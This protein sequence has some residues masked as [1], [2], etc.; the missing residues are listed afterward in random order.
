[1]QRLANQLLSLSSVE[2]INGLAR[3]RAPVDLAV[4][5][6]DVAAD[7][8]LLAIERQIDLGFESNL[9]GSQALPVWGHD[10]LLRDMVLNLVDNALRYTQP[11]GSVTVA[12]SPDDAGQS[13]C[14]T[15]SDTGPGIAPAERD[16]VFHRFYR[17]LGETRTEGSGL[18]L[19]IVR[20]I[21]QAHE[22]RIQLADGA[23]GRGLLVAVCLPRAP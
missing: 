13:V 15:V 11:G 23:G 6:R 21:V 3:D 22:G 20:E 2:A 18:G 4:L 1:M 9:I 19:A 16:K 17:I 8:S 12:V 5:A 10:A 14:L 7:L